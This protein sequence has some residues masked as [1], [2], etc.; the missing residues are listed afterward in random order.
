MMPLTAGSTR[1]VATTV[2]H[3]GIVKVRRFAVDLP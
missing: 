2:V 1:P 3:A